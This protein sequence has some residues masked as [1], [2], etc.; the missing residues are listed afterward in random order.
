[1][2]EEIGYRVKVGE[3]TGVY[4]NMKAWRPLAGIPL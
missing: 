2:L 4:K 1:V 3:L